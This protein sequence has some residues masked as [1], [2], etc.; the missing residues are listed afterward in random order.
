MKILLIHADSMEY[1]PTHKVMVSGREE[2][3][4][5]EWTRVED[6]LVAFVAVE[7]K[8]EFAKKRAAQAASNEI[9]I[10]AERVRARRIIVYP[11]AHLTTELGSLRQQWKFSRPWK[12][13]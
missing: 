12:R 13:D 9:G 8:D 11:F 2:L 4:R 3:E 5:K 10:V 6:V 7:R 1:K